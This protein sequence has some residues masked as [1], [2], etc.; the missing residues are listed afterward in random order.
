MQDSFKQIDIP[1]E[2]H[3][4]DSK[5]KFE[6]CIECDKYLLEDDVDYFIEKAIKKYDGFSAQDV[7]FEYAICLTCAEHMRTKMSTESLQKLESYFMQ[8][9]DVFKR[10][11]LLET[12]NIGTN[13]W[14]EECIIS[15]KK[16]EMINEYQLFAQ[17]RGDKMILGH[18]PYMVSGEILEKVAELLSPETKDELDNFSKRHFGPPPE[19]KEPLPYQRVLIV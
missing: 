16:M 2:F 11:D 1:E 12:E 17:C 4:F 6:R 18:M 10:M 3:S 13:A 9:M 19:L 7:I 15:G 8:N 14:Y 5:S